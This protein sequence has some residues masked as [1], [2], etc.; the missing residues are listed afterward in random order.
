M[1]NATYHVPVVQTHYA[2]ILV[3][4]FSDYGLNKHELLSD[5][6]LPA[7]LFNMNSDFLPSES[8]KRLIFLTSSQLGVTK[9]TDLLTLVLRRRIIPNVLHQFAS[10][11]TIGNAMEHIADI[12]HIDS[13]GSAVSFEMNHGHTWFCRFSDE[14]NTTTSDWSEMFAIIYITELI[15]TLTNTK[16]V[17]S[18]V[19]LQSRCGDIVKSALPNQCQVFIGQEQT[20]VYIPDDILSIPIQISESSPATETPNIQWHTSFTDSV[21]ELLRPYVRERNLSVE[22]AAQ[23]L[24]FSVRTF[25][26]KLKNEGTSFRHIKESLMYCVSCEL[27]EEGHSLTYISNQLGYTSISHFSRAFKR[28]SGLSP[29]VYKRSIALNAPNT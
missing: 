14:A 28:V 2:R 17:P 18:K 27:M 9:F 10:F 19:R 21:F 26:R 4:V 22:D 5:A 1:T 7:D 29:K 15:C 20:G 3:E 11:D 12:F 25:Q 13:P 24:S 6:G 23:L 16:W 8:I